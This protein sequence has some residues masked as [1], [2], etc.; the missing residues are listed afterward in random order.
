MPASNLKSVLLKGSK[1]ANA[2]QSLKAKGTDKVLVVARAKTVPVQLTVTTS[3]H[4]LPVLS[5]AQ[6]LHSNRVGLLNSRRKRR[7]LSYRI[8][9]DAD[10]KEILALLALLS[11]RNAL[12]AIAA[13]NGQQQEEQVVDEGGD[14]NPFA[15][16]T[17]EFLNQ[18]QPQVEDQESEDE[19]QFPSSFSRSR[20]VGHRTPQPQ[21]SYQQRPKFETQE[22]VRLGFQPLPLSRDPSAYFAKPGA[23]GQFTSLYRPDV[24]DDENVARLYSLSNIL[25]ENKRKYD[26]RRK[27]NLYRLLDSR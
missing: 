22:A 23:W 15:R 17:Y 4:L 25:A 12:E 9:R 27:R 7:A 3:S 24:S 14:T 1:E 16:A 18:R 2:V 5:R 8:K 20:F 21:P 6:R 26:E 19:P 11:D 10:P 13:N